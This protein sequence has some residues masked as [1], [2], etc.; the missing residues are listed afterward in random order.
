MLSHS[1][2][3]SDEVKLLP[4]DSPS[5]EELAHRLT[6]LPEYRPPPPEP[7]QRPQFSVGDVLVVMVGVAVGLSGGTWIRADTFA[8]ILGL[9][10][11]LGLLLVH[12]YPP[13]SHLGKLIWAT[14][15]LAYVMAVAAALLKPAAA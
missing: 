14:M 7:T 15:V 12:L 11:L 5:R 13:Q 6:P 9:A 10:T 4:P 2:L 1:E 8:A 3:H